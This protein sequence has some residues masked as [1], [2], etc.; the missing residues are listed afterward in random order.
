VKF[1]E[2]REARWSGR[3]GPFRLE[4]ELVAAAEAP[5]A[6]GA[7]RLRLRA[8]V[9]LFRARNGDV[10]LLRN[11]EPTEFVVRDP[12]PDDAALLLGLAERPL[13]VAAGDEAAQRL[14]PLVD[15]G[16]VI[17][18]ALAAREL[19][20]AQRFARQLPYL[21]EFA[22]PLEAQRRLRASTVAVLG[23]G[24]LGTW[25]LGAIASLGVGRLVLVDHDNVELSNL[26]RQ[27]LY[28]P[29]DIGT[30]K[31][32]CA[33]RWVASFDP[34]I[35][36][37]AHREQVGSAEQVSSLVRGA[38]ALLQLAD[39]P[40]YELER[41]VNAACVELGVAHLSAAQQPPVLRIG[42]AYV[43]GVTACFECQERQIRDGFPLYDELTEWRRAHV[44]PATTLG[45]AS[46]IVGTLLAMETLHLLLGVPAATQ[47]R[48]M[49]LDM[50]TLECEWEDLRRDASCPVCATAARRR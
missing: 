9:E 15:A 21:G 2:D 41:W 26:N 27:I 50:R 33:A 49:V 34:A 25:A 29:A 47:G 43:P 40:P 19:D 12:D 8:S 1:S 38:D 14:A 37:V 32:E 4:G 46:G 22:E 31:V 35:E 11:G 13:E 48:A 45:P 23:C 36:V 17:E 7:S 28:S 44:Q 39:W 16:L 30:P 6:G 24:G 18:E 42:P 10:Y 20:G 5:P 3:P